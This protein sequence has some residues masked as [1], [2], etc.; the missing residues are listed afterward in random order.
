MN[1][2]ISVMLATKMRNLFK[3]GTNG[4]LITDWLVHKQEQQSATQTHWH[5]SSH[6]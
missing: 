2:F 6:T 3:E 4:K 5:K 1:R